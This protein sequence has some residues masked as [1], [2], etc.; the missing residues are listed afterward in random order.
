MTFREQGGN[1]RKTFA[2]VINLRDE[3]CHPLLKWPEPLRAPEA[4]EGGWS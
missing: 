4:V 2:L 1:R 3:S